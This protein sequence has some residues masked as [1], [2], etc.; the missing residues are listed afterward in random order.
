MVSIASTVKE[1]PIELIK[2]KHVLFATDFSE[3][4]LAA[5]PHVAALARHYGSKVYLAH[6]IEPEAYPP[7]LRLGPASGAFG[8]V[9]QDCQERLAD[10][11][12]SKV[13]VGVAREPLV[14]HGELTRVLSEVIRQ[15]PIDL[16]VVG[17]HG[18][19]GFKR[20]L[21][22]SVAE[23]I[24]RHAAC[25]VLT[26]GPR[27]HK[28][29]GTAEAS[30]RHILYPTDLSE[31]GAV[32]ARYAVSLAAEYSAHLTVL[33]I[34]P[35]AVVTDALLARELEQK[36]QRLVPSEAEP[37]CNADYLVDHGDPAETILKVAREELADLIVLDVRKPGALAMFL[38]STAYQVVA[39]AGCPVLTVRDH[40]AT[41]DL[42][43]WS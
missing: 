20:F 13:L 5:L 9:G 18:R 1:T 3:A 40:P 22:G 7:L 42:A 6:V 41:A 34:S 26:V 39:E 33:H 24:F 28:V 43:D 8:E 36:M 12:H 15:L 27:T 29:L 35:D 37:W 30:F 31:K 2:L 19:G 17:T 25:P 4:S 23:K 16:V 38:E 11:S 21:L 10:V 32:A 14:L